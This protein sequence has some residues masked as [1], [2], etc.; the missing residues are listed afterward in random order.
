MA[1]GNSK[2]FVLANFLCKG[3]ILLHPTVQGD[4][5]EARSLSRVQSF[6]RSLRSSFRRRSS[7]RATR[8]PDDRSK[9]AASAN[10]G[11]MGIGAR[12]PQKRA[13][14]EPLTNVANAEGEPVRPEQI[15]TVSNLVFAET[16]VTGREWGVSG[17]RRE[18]GGEWAH[19]EGWV[20]KGVW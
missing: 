12:N 15:G 19:H 9:I 10:V 18:D 17:W 6:R 3:I 1:A 14:S 20:E 16:Y 8:E 11:C 5:V 13:A 7:T 2:G 4:G